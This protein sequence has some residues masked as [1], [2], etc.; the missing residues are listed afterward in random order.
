[1]QREYSCEKAKKKNP[2]VT[3]Q[4]NPLLRLS[5]IHFTVILL[6]QIVEVGFLFSTNVIAVIPWCQFKWMSQE[7]DV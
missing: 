4:E 6:A 1:M 5:T 7:S 3:V 2:I